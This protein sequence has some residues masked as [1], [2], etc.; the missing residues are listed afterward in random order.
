MT[1]QWTTVPFT[2]KSPVTK[3]GRQAWLVRRIHDL[4]AKFLHE[5]WHCSLLTFRTN[6]CSYCLSVS[7]TQLSSLGLK[8]FGKR[9]E[10]LQHGSF[11]QL[12]SRPS[13]PVKDSPGKIYPMSAAVCPN[14]GQPGTSYSICPNVNCLIL[15]VKSSLLP[16]HACLQSYQWTLGIQ[17]I[18]PQRP[19]SKVHQFKK[20][21]L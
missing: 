20:R 1:D 6:F 7:F 21:F 15:G 12:A 10:D 14:I 17:R 5:G 8:K 13:E 9:R 4:L 3:W 11:T 18:L 19:P 16:Q 2:T